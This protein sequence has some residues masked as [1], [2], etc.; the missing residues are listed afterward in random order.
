MVPIRFDDHFRGI[1][2]LGVKTMM[3]TN[4]S[5]RFSEAF[6]LAR[7]RSTRETPVGNPAN[8]ILITVRALLKIRARDG[9]RLNRLVKGDFQ[10]VINKIV[11]PTPSFSITF[12]LQRH[13]NLMSEI[14]PT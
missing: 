12:F 11:R 3:Y 1:F 10:S 14:E 9:I 2:N 6:D 13:F 5:N 4:R 8:S 7:F